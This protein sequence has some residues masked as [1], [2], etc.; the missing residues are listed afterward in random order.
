[1]KAATLMAALSDELA[2]PEKKDAAG[3]LNLLPSKTGGILM[4]NHKPKRKFFSFW[5]IIGSVACLFFLAALGLWG[6]AAKRKQEKEQMANEMKQRDAGRRESSM[7]PAANEMKLFSD[8]MR[9]SSMNLAAIA[10]HMNRFEKGWDKGL[11]PTQRNDEI[12][13]RY[14][15]TQTH[16]ASMLGDGVKFFDSA[17]Y[18]H[19]PTMR[20]AIDQYYA[21]VRDPNLSPQERANALS[22]LQVSEQQVEKM[23]ALAD[24]IEEMKRYDPQVARGMARQGPWS[25]P[26]FR[27]RVGFPMT[28]PAPPPAPS[29]APTPQYKPGQG[30][31]PR[32]NAE[33][34]KLNR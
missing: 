34:F 32:A 4:N 12:F 25:N 11:S 30:Q 16:G 1:V 24:E 20:A 19:Y 5:S 18:K 33:P 28:P 26:D 3:H 29:P 8:Y 2:V 27:S 10:Q 15:I 9:E 23:E 31:A 6:A 21:K 17:T 7:S 14:A 22:H 13:R